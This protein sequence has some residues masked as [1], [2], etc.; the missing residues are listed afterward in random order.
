MGAGGGNGGSGDGWGQ[1]DDLM[2]RAMPSA[3][4]PSAPPTHTHTTHPPVEGLMPMTLVP[5]NV[6]RGGCHHRCSSPP[7]PLQRAAGGGGGGQGARKTLQASMSECGC[8]RMSGG[9]ECGTHPQTTSA[10][11][12]STA[13]T[14][15]RSCPAH[16]PLLLP[17]RRRR[18]CA[19]AAAP[20][21]HA[22]RPAGGD[23]QRAAAPHIVQHKGGREHAAQEGD[24][25]QVACPPPARWWWVG[26]GWRGGG[27]RWGRRQSF[28]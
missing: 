14:A 17:C 23:L 1:L 26:R 20:E 15:L 6:R 7:L 10:L 16:S 24:V 12:H 3:C 25:E 11:Q 19:A 9:S 27:W 8:Y 18:R 21:A 4:Q 22:H 28:V 2:R 13:H 5:V